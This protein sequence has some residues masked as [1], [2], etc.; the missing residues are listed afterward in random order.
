MGAFGSTIGGMLAIGSFAIN[1]LVV[2]RL[3][4]NM[5][6][7]YAF[8]LFGLLG[9]IALGALNGRKARTQAKYKNEYTSY[10]G[11]FFMAIILLGGYYAFFALGRI[12][13]KLSPD[14][15][16]D[17]NAMTVLFLSVVAGILGFIGFGLAIANSLSQEGY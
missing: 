11:T 17:Y 3:T 14:F 13:D 10:A 8:F 6:V 2:W 1:T 9:G 7:L 16:A 12:E 5:F 15:S 4:E